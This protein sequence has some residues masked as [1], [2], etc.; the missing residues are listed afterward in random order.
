MFLGL[1][2]QGC[3]DTILYVVILPHPVKITQII[4]PN[5]HY[6]RGNIP[7]HTPLSLILRY[8]FKQDLTQSESATDLGCQS[9][10][11]SLDSTIDSTYPSRDLFGFIEQNA[12]LLIMIKDEDQRLCHMSPT[13]HNSIVDVMS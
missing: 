4:A 13:E 2:G 9:L 10:M 7:N 3:F 11:K 12:T 6:E 5:L 1:D 8:L